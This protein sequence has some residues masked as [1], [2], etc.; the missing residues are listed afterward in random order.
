MRQ[1]TL[2]TGSEKKA[3][4][5][6]AM[7]PSVQINTVNTDVDEIQ[8]LDLEEIARKKARAVFNILNVPVVVDDTG[9]YLEDWKGLPGPFIK[10]FEQKFPKESMARMLGNASNRRAYSRTCIAYCDGE[11]EFVVSGEAH[12]MVTDSPRGP[13]DRFGFDYCFVPDG[14]DQTFAELGYDLKNTISHRARALHAF[15]ERIE[16]L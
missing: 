3:A 11:Q 16:T 12:G 7:L 8:S 15:K 9:F 14:Y 10:Y 6:R 5:Y 4:E 13:E 1:F 2:V